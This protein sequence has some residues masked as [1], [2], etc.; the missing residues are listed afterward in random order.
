MAYS[1]NNSDDMIGYHQ[2]V[3]N[4]CIDNAIN[5]SADEDISRIVYNNLRSKADIETNFLPH[6]RKM[7]YRL[8]K[9]PAYCLIS[10]K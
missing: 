3:A 8:S 9:K 10:F 4:N 1:V 2:K 7:I 5:Y 6:Q